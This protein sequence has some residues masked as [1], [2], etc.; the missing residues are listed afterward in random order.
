MT[1]QEFIEFWNG[2][3]VETA[4]SSD[5]LN[6]CTDLANAYLRD[7][8]Q[9][10]I[11]EWTNAIDFP[12]KLTNFD[13]IANTPTNIP[14]EGDLIIWKPSPGHIALFIEGN[15]DS[16]ISFDQN[17]PTDSPCHIQ[18]HDYTN[19]L[20]WCRVKS[21]AELIACQKQVTDEIKK[22]NETWEELK[23][24][25]K[26][27]DEYCIRLGNAAFKLAEIKKITDDRWTWIGNKGW[28]N[29]LSQLKALLV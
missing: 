5:A 16:F 21:S 26:D 14:K 25:K 4:G 22:K 10:P 29:R 2:K 12:S 15:V 28:K 19:V 11:V 24:V 3:Y 8:L 9:Q 23:T 20:G 6:Q 1:P 7:V 13:F 27:L 17:Y 18:E